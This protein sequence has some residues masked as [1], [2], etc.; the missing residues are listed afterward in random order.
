MFR[1]QMCILG[2]LTVLLLLA[3]LL[4]VEREEELLSARTDIRQTRASERERADRKHA[5]GERGID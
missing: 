3:L 4:H 2:S 5:P 1:K